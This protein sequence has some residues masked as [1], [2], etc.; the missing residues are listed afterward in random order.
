MDILYNQIKVYVVKNY[1]IDRLEE[2]FMNI[3]DFETIRSDKKNQLYKK[4]C[5]KW[6]AVVVLLLI[7]IHFFPIYRVMTAE[8][9]GYYER[10]E[11][12]KILYIGSYQ[13]R[14]AVQP[15]IKQARAALRD[16]EWRTKEENQE[17][18]GLLAQYVPYHPDS[19]YIK[20]HLRLWSAHLDEHEGY[21]WVY[22]SQKVLND[23]RDCIQGVWRATA[24]WKV[25]KNDQGEWIVV[26]IREAP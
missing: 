24:L 25:Q 9:T 18:Y 26:E 23:E 16:C 2:A 8:A 17:K 19:A 14:A 1:C 3:N 10:E 22:Y 12:E 15:I 5:K 11:L 7:L 21:M 20:S 6:V 13:D 4:L